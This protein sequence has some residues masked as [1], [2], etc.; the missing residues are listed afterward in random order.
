MGTNSLVPRPRLGMRLGHKLTCKFLRNSVCVSSVLEIW[1]TVCFTAQWA[2]QCMVDACHSGCF[3]SCLGC[4]RTGI[5][6][7]GPK[8]SGHPRVAAGGRGGG[9]DSTRT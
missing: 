4:V 1:V 9:S 5:V 7:D 8:Y 2:P 6:C 3:H